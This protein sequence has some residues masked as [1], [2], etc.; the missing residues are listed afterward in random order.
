MNAMIASKTQ[1]LTKDA[2]RHRLLRYAA[3]VGWAFVTTA[4]AQ[5]TWV[6]RDLSDEAPSS[7]WD[8]LP[9]VGQVFDLGGDFRNDVAFH[10]VGT[11]LPSMV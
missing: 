6:P 7:G 3:L 5:T 9:N 11:S 4:W 10:S 1:A 8:F 2:G